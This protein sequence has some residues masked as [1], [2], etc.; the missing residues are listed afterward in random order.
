MD[1]QKRKDS[2]TPRSTIKIVKVGCKQAIER[3][4]DYLLL[5]KTSK[6]VADCFLRLMRD[7]RENEVRREREIET[8]GV[9]EESEKN[10]TVGVSFRVFNNLP[11]ARFYST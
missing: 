8:E 3:C 7:E 6:D 4:A 1:D 2:D 11:I 10:W 5:L 9:G